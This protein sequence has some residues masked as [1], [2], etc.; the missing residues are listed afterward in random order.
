MQGVGK[1]FFGEL[2]RCCLGDRNVGTVSPGQV[3]SDFNGWATNVSVNVLEEL[4][5]KGHNRYDA[6]NSL[7]PL[8]TDRMIQINDKGVKQYMTYN[9][10]N[11]ICFTNYKDS[12]PIDQDD[13]RWWVIFTQIECLSDLRSFVGEDAITYFPKLFNAVRTYGGEI[14]KWLLDYK[15][16]DEFL[17]IKQAPMTDSKLSMIATEEASFEGY[18]EVKELIEKGGKYYNKDVVSATDLFEQLE[19]LYPEVSV[20]TSKRHILMKKLGFSVISKQVKIDG[21]LR[22]IWA[23]K[24]LTYE[25]IRISLEEKVLS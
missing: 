16:S 7:K 19:F 10:T 15:L 25:E 6:I 8:V 5:V 22:R 13:R 14:R 9:T 11:Y 18:S 4:R 17:S 20:Q 1:S 24:V 23:K 21:K 3:I 12:L 2:L